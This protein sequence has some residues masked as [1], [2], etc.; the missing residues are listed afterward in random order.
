MESMIDDLANARLAAIVD[1]SDDAIVG[2]D[3]TGTITAWNPAAEEL[4]GYSAK[5]AI[6]SKITMIAPPGREPEMREII[7]K[8]IQGEKVDHFETQRR[9][10]DGSIID[11]AVTVSP[12]YDASGRVVGASKIARG[13]GEQKRLR[14]EKGL[15]AAIVSASDDAI[16]SKD[17]N[18]TITSWNG[19]AEELFGYS[20]EEA[21]GQHISLIALP[22][23]VEEM[24]KILQR[25]RHG[26]RVDHFETQRRSKN[27]AIVEI[28]LTVSPIFDDSGRVIGASKVA[29]DIGER[30]RTEERLRLLV[31]ELDHRAKNVLAVTQAMLRLTRADNVPDYVNALEGRIRAL[32]RVHSRVA[33]SNWSGADIRALAAADVDVFSDAGE[34]MTAEGDSVWVS[35]AAA[36]VIAIVLHE[37]STNAAKYGALSAEAGSVAIRWHRDAAGDLRLLWTE[38]GGPAVAEPSRRG[39]GSQIV[40]RGIPDQ[41]GG[42]AEMSWPPSGL[43]CAFVVPA[44]HIVDPARKAATGP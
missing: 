42:S 29:R 12:I 6:G 21:I 7:E 27:G 10:K 31:R 25:I 28:S 13:I 30:R 1:S 2:K 23:R 40:E 32:A 34:R 11:I 37:L 20:A 3:L 39:F 33:E 43:R 17:L 41:L 16:I 24:Q 38:E 26:Q 14:A 44:A 8:I 5:E 19:S 22:D 18:G 4:F 36:Q 15:L 9:R 35:P